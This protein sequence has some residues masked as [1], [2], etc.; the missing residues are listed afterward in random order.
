MTT[1]DL[2]PD[3]ACPRHDPSA[4]QSGGG[5]QAVSVT[6]TPSDDLAACRAIRHQVFVVEQQVS[7]ADELDGLDDKA[8][9]LIARQDGQP[10]G[11]A[12]LLIR[13]DCGK[14][15]R[16]AVLAQARGAGLGAGLILAALEQF[17]Q[18]PQITCAI[19]GAQVHALG[20]YEKLGFRPYGPVYNDAGIAHRD[21]KRP[22]P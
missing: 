19:L 17:R 18:M 16:V 21:M 7:E 22:L 1:D 5:A 6:I 10:L 13:G 14:I 20:F 15:T 4:P 2:A 8:I 12:R 9:H 3:T 11:T